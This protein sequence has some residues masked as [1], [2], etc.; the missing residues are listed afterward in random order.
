LE[1]RCSIDQTKVV[2]NKVLGIQR[3]GSS[4]VKGKGERIT[5]PS[6]E[7][8]GRICWSPR[9]E[10]AKR[11]RGEAKEQSPIALEWDRKRKRS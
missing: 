9:T 6:K 10:F 5:V 1:E 2:L 11:R 3:R 4:T 7:G 8:V